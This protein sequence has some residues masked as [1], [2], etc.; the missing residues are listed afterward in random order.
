MSLKLREAIELVG[1]IRGGDRRSVRARTAELLETLDLEE[2]AGTIG[3]KLSGGV[4]RLA[5]FAMAIVWPTRLVILDEPTNDI[6]PLRRRRLWQLIR[7]LGSEGTAV[8]LVTHNVLE[9]EQ[10]VDRLAVID[11]GRIL[12]QGTPA[13]MKREDRDHLRLQLSL[14]PGSQAPELPSFTLRHTQL[15][16]RLHLVIDEHRASEAIV[17]AQAMTAAG[18]VE[19]YALAATTL[20]DVYIRLIGRDDALEGDALE[21]PAELEA[22][23]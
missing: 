8:L 11:G 23:A 7:R 16:R 14:V 4:K 21:A 22:T 13:F 20:E 6:D 9:A 1:R 5:G 2:W 12:E 17:W 18:G 3:M 19:E 15:S 10:V